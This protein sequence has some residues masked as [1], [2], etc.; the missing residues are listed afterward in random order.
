MEMKLSIQ[1][2]P[3]LLGSS[4]LTDGSENGPQDKAKAAVAV[5]QT[6]D[7]PL[8]V[9]SEQIHVLPRI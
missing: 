1:A 4:V 3:S 7:P 8:P 2:A 9:D 6:I 5:V